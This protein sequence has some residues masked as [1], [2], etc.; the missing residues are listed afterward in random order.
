MD[1]GLRLGLELLGQLEEGP[2][3]LIQGYNLML[4]VGEAMEASV[5][6]GQELV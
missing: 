5:G 4:I 3:V 2:L 6:R 1:R